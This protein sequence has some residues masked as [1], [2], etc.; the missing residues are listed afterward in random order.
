MRTTPISVSVA[1]A[2]AAGSLAAAPSL[3][4]Q[5]VNVSA[6]LL[7]TVEAVYA[8]DFVPENVGQQPDFISIVLQSGTTTG[9]RILLRV[10]IRQEAPRSVLLFT[11]TSKAFLLS[12]VRRITNRDLSS[13]NSDVVLDDYEVSDAEKE[14]QEQVLHTGRFPSGTYA[15]IVEALNSTTRAVLGRSEVR[16]EL[17]N[18]TRVELLSPGRPFGETPELLTSTAPRFQWTSDVGLSSTG[19]TD[20]I[21]VVPADGAA[22]PEEAMQQFPNWDATTTATTALYPGSVSAK[23][24]EAGKT[25][26]WQVTREVRTSGGSQFI[27]SPIYWF[28]MQ[29]AQQTTSS[30]GQAASGDLGAAVQLEQLGRALGLG[31]DLNGFRPTGSMLVDGKPVTAENLEAL[32]RAILA[33]TVTVH[34]ITVR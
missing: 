14:F 3:R 22:S 7:Y 16:L 15:F 34:S 2:L 27:N 1:L 21:K 11:G 19:G 10:T 18:P 9:Q 32:L 23:P 17:D 5:S 8:A 20:R 24:L 4:A 29:G 25:Y 6:Q 28:K 26:A 31:G 12:G 13:N 33:G 30:T